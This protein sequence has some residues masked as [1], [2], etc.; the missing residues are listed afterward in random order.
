MPP[1]SRKQIREIVARALQEMMT[2]ND[3]VREA[4]AGLA[5]ADQTKPAPAHYTAP[6]TG[7]TYAAQHPSQFQFNVTEGA[8][9]GRASEILDLIE[10]KLCSIEKNKSCD[11]CGMCRSLGF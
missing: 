8:L 2:E 4:V 3:A 6:W 9:Q 11:H 7:Q 10:T 5:A 1:V